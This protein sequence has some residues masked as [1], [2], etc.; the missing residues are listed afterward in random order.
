VTNQAWLDRWAQDQIGFHRD[1]PNRSLLAH[2]DR[3]GP[4]VLVPLAGK[5]REMRVLAEAG[6][7]VVG[8]ELA[9]KAARAFFAEWGPI[10][11]VERAAH[12]I[13]RAAGVEMHVADLFGDG[14]LEIPPCDSAFDRAA[15]VAIEPHRRRAY[16][17][18][19]RR[20]LRP[21]GNILLISFDYPEAEMSGPPFSVGSSVIAGLFPG[22]R[23]E[24][25]EERQILA[26]EPKFAARGVS[27]LVEAC[28]L[29]TLAR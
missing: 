13:H 19:L 10:P 29:I 4:R 21:G 8:I 12:P 27:R 15:L 26:E 5:A 20:L 2:L 22:D 18:R 23:V 1:E 9:E 25:L 17:E 28:D 6:R 16:V 24:R 11:S 14:V 7:E 3:L